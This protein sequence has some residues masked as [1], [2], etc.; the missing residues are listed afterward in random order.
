MRQVAGISASQ[1][2]QRRT[3]AHTA[4]RAEEIEDTPMAAPATSPSSGQRDAQVCHRSAIYT[5]ASTADSCN[6]AYAVPGDDD[7]AGA[8]PSLVETTTQKVLA[9]S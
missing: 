2:E 3:A 7:P 9:C 6:D 4:R 8:A 5:S 1:T